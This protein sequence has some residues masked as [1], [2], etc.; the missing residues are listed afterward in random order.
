MSEPDE[1]IEGQEEQPE[2][3]EMGAP[4]PAAEAKALIDLNTAT[5][6]QLCQLPGIGPVLAARI[7]NYRVEVHPF[8]ETVEI[9]AV[10]GISEATY[11]RLA[12]RLT[13]GPED[14]IEAERGAELEVEPA[15]MEEP[16]A[17]EP[18]PEAKI[19][20]MPAPQPDREPIR[21]ADIPTPRPIPRPA[22]ARGMGWGH[23]LLVAV[24]G[25]VAGAILAL[26]VLLIINGTLNF[27]TATVQA[28]QTETFRLGKEIGRLDGDMRQLQRRL[29]ALQDLSARLDE[30]QAGIGQLREGM[31]AAREQ[32]GSM[33]QTMDALRQEFTNLRE[34]LDGMAGH[35]SVQGRRLDEAEQRLSVLA[36]Q[37][38]EISGAAQRF[39]GF[40]GG[41][42]HLLN[43]TLG[44]PTPTP[45]QTPMP[46]PMVTVIPLA[47]PTRAP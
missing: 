31:S 25:A 5:E 26:I 36:K 2:S 24:V 18:E 10:P 3:E 13:V 4:E 7:V 14:E 20:E 19:E 15:E 17:P 9:T 11:T 8:E 33:A 45:W 28:L 22:A 42:R 35:V 30:T 38:E 32:M 21:V 47:T 46:A 39:D 12:D 1:L 16:P 40:L 43:E 41:L 44:P 29:E 27:R 6:E 23:L 37:L 34:D